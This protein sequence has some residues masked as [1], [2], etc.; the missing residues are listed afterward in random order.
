MGAASTPRR[1]QEG[2]GQG[3]QAP[4]REGRRRRGGGLRVAPCS[5]EFVI[6][7]IQIESFD[8]SEQYCEN[9][10]AI[11]FLFFILFLVGG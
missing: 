10:R 9:T 1:G 6:Y 7:I 8:N 2:A 11:A 5:N 3:G 4:P